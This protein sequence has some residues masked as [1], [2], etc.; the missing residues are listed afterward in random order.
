MDVVAAMQP[1][2]ESFTQLGDP[3]ERLKRHLIG[4]GAWSDAEH[5]KARQA[6]DAEVAA[7]LKQAQTY[8]GALV[9]NHVPP[10]T[11]NPRA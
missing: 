7:A 10:L 6:F 3:V 4:L 9:D 11:N 5:E 1:C 2:C 8:G